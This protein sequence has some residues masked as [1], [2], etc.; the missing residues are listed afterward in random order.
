MFSIRLDWHETITA[1]APESTHAGSPQSRRGCKVGAYIS[2][3]V[4]K[5]ALYVIAFLCEV[6]NRAHETK[7]STV[8]V[9]GKDVIRIYEKGRILFEGKQKV[10][11]H[12]LVLKAQC[13]REV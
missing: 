13:N 6:D 5:R 4:R 8:L 9:I 11:S 12:I 7:S 3:Q 1:G 10:S 2:L